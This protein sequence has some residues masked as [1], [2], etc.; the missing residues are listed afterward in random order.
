VFSSKTKIG[1]L[2][3]GH[4]V[5]G[6]LLAWADYDRPSGPSLGF[7]GLFSLVLSEVGL[8]GI[9]CALGTSRTVV[10]LATVL[11]TTGY[12]CALFTIAEMEVLRKS[13]G[14]GVE[15]ALRTAWPTAVIF[16]SLS[17]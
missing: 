5:A 8:L 2:V 15:I 14:W 12:L 1:L 13:G 16:L 3:A 7:I 11:L 4:F 17:G 10:R 6:L 9:W